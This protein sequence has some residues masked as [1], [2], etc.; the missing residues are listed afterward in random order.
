[1]LLTPRSGPIPDLVF[2]LAAALKRG[3]IRPSRNLQLEPLQA[4]L[5]GPNGAVVANKRLLDAAQA[6]GLPVGWPD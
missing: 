4:V 2:L 3:H 5:V 6:A 1:M